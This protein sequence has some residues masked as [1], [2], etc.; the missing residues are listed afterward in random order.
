MLNQQNNKKINT[1]PFAKSPIH[2]FKMLYEDPVL[3]NI[4]DIDL[5]LTNP[6][7]V[8]ESQRNK[9][10]RPSIRDSYD[11]LG[12]IIYPIIVCKNADHPDRYIHID[13]YGR[14]EHIKERGE[15]QV[16]AYVF[17]HMNLEQRICFRETL[18]AAQEPF[19]AASIIHDLRLLAQERDLNIYNSEHVETL[20][21]DLPE[22]VQKHKKD[23]IE[24]SRWH[25]DVIKIIGESYDED[26]KSIGLDQVR[27]LGRIMTVMDKNHPSTLKKLGGLQKLSKQLAQMYLDRRFSEN[28]K[29]QQGIRTVTKSLKMLKS[30][31]PYILKF[32]ETG[33]SISDLGKTAKE[34][35]PNERGIV[36]D[37]CTRFFNILANLNTKLLTEEEKIILQRTSK[38]L[39]DVLSEVGK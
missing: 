21:R 35:T 1:T 22:R 26:P 13:G 15:K 5:D 7:S 34:T 28:G 24:L 20:V 32:F 25:P 36:L 10:R 6:G 37:S 30:D 38:V 33:L 31:D 23:I 39:N 27:G 2:N 9:R 4:A 16:R 3:L 17:P 11:I 12:Q 18:N 29:S 8:S 14:L 19:D